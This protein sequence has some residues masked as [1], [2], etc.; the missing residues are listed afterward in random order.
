MYVT[1]DEKKHKYKAKDDMVKKVL[2]LEQES[3]T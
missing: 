2:K 3:T 1:K